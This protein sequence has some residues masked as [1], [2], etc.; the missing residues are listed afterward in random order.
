MAYYYINGANSRNGYVHWTGMVA[1]YV[2]QLKGNRTSG[3][4]LA[5]ASRALPNQLF[6]PQQRPSRAGSPD[7]GYSRHSGGPDELHRQRTVN[8]T[9]E[10]RCLTTERSLFGSRRCSCP[11]YRG[12]G[13]Y[14]RARCTQRHLAH[15]R[16]SNQ[17]P[18][19]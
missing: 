17:I 19:Y 3:Y 8:A 12:S 14:R 7:T 4:A 9:Q 16:R 5:I 13:D 6:G 15:R 11:G 18:P 1:P 2:K 10:I